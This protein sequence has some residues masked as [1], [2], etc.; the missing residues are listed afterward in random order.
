MKLYQLAYGIHMQEDV[1]VSL[2]QVIPIINNLSQVHL[3]LRNPKDANLCCKHLLSA[4]AY[5]RECGGEQSSTSSS[6]I[7]PMDN[8]L[9]GYFSNVMHLVLSDGQVATAA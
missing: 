5:V 6:S 8:Q 1:D 4:L 3:A 9:E 7:S 2:Y